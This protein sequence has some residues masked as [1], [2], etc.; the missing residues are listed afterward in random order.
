M[1]DGGVL[2][3]SL[4]L[5]WHVCWIRA[6]PVASSAVGV[7]SEIGR[8]SSDPPPDYLHCV[9]CKYGGRGPDDVGGGRHHQRKAGPELSG[10]SRRPSPRPLPPPPWPSSMCATSCGTLHL[11]IL[12][13]AA[14]QGL[15]PRFP[16]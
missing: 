13:R 9:C 15:R 2:A 4:R 14:G 16:G 8:R 12:S 7:V 10:A 11:G 6:G 3:R 1:P 5:P